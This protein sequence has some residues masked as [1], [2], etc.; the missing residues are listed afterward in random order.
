MTLSRI[1][2]TKWKSFKSIGKL[3]NHQYLDCNTETRI[4]W[5]QIFRTIIRGNFE[6][7]SICE[8]TYLDKHRP[9]RYTCIEV[10]SQSIYLICKAKKKR[11][12]RVSILTKF[13]HEFYNPPIQRSSGPKI[14]WFNDLKI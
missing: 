2:D 13:T 12:K 8:N 6:K 4:P 10:I 9:Q 5:L 11:K 7:S 1:I 14:Q 3:F